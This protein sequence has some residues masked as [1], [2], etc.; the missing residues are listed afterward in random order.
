MVNINAYSNTTQKSQKHQLVK[1]ITLFSLI[2]LGIRMSNI[3]LSGAAM[4]K[5]MDKITHLG[6][7]F[8]IFG[9]AIILLSLYVKSDNGLKIGLLTLIFGG[10]FR[11]LNGFTEAIY[12]PLKKKKFTYYKFF[13][14]T[15]IRFIVWFALIVV[16]IYLINKVISIIQF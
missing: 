9:G 4:G 16:Y 5:I 7:S 1:F 3:S 15:S 12:E 2:L 11:L 13:L 8:I 6:S 14:I 10:I